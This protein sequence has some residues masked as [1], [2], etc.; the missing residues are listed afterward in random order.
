[1]A[2]K[3]QP[4]TAEI[5]ER[6]RSLLGDYKLAEKANRKC[7]NHPDRIIYMKGLCTECYEIE[8]NTTKAAKAAKEPWISTDGYKYCYDSDG[9]VVLHA[10]VVASTY[11]GRKLNSSEKISYLDGNPTNTSLENL[12]VSVPVPVTQLPRALSSRLSLTRELS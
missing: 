8:T 2:K 4:S 6:A 3:K 5:L 12:A 9:K 10:R 7:K 11:L 1:M